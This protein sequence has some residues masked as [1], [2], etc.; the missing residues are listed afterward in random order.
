MTCSVL[1]LWR[2]CEMRIDVGCCSVIYS[3]IF[4]SMVTLE[5]DLHSFLVCDFTSLNCSVHTM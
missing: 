4:H 1:T 5:L 2:N 3:L